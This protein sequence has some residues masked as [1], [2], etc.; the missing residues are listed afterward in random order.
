[1]INWFLEVFSCLQANGRIFGGMLPTNWQKV[2][3]QIIL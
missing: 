3:P 1:M 2:I